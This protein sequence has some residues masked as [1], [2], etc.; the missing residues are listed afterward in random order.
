MGNGGD[1]GC[2]TRTT[3]V[4]QD[5]RRQSHEVTE[6]ITV[7]SLTLRLILQFYVLNF[8]ASLKEKTK[9]R[10]FQALQQLTTRQLQ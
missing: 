7:T 10:V 5:A 4:L 2:R 3:S 9:G 1:R 8:A 6:H